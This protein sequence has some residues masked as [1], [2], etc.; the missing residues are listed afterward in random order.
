M[1]SNSRS[2][3][4]RHCGDGKHVPASIATDTK[5]VRSGHKAEMEIDYIAPR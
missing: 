4:L 2:V 3:L 5:L 1:K